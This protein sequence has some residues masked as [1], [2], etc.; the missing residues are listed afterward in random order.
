M[1]KRNQKFI[2]NDEST[3]PD[4]VV[5]C[6]ERHKN[7]LLAWEQN[8]EGPQVVSFRAVPYGQRANGHMQIR[9]GCFTGHQRFGM[10]LACVHM[11]LLIVI[12]R[13][14]SVA[15]QHSG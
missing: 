2:V 4:E 13:A 8:H 12:T 15:P 10:R 7:I 5:D 11:F 1:E 3:W 9:G 14:L 6:F